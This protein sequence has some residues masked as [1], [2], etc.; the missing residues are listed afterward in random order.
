MKFKI[1]RVLSESE[2]AW[3]RKWGL[4]NYKPYSPR[5]GHWHPVVQEECVRINQEADGIELP[6]GTGET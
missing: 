5:D 1:H 4:A 6:A 3:F 2:A